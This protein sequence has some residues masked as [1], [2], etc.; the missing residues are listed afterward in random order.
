MKIKTTK[1]CEISTWESRE[2]FFNERE[3]GNGKKP[4][5][6]ERA[7]EWVRDNDLTKEGK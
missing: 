1:G 7:N 6:D 5:N 3:K 2:L 4:Q